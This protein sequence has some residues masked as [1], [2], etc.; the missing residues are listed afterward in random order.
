MAMSL[1]FIVV[2]RPWVAAPYLLVST[3]AG[4][5]V[6]GMLALSAATSV[7]A[8]WLGC[9]LVWNRTPSLPLGLYWLSRTSRPLAVSDI[10]VFPV[11]A[12]VRGLVAERRYLP[13][14]VPLLKPVVAVAGD[15]VCTSGGTTSVNGSPFGPVLRTDS[16][17]REL[18]VDALCGP[19][20]PGHVY[21]ATHHPRSFDSRTFGPVDLRTVQGRATP[22]WTY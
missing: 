1:G 15:R 2:V 4:R 7:L 22:L 13:P 6:L 12:N 18:P 14:G 8:I 5:W 9:H 10:A 11:P 20:P 21:V 3:R 16:Q 19:V 17:G